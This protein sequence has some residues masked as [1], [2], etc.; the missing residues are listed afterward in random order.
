MKI[1]SEKRDEKRK[2]KK[3]QVLDSF[4]RKYTDR[5]RT[6]YSP[7]FILQSVH[8]LHTQYFFLLLFVLVYTHSLVARTIENRLFVMWIGD[9][10]F[11]LLNAD[12]DH[13]LYRVSIHFYTQHSMFIHIKRHIYASIVHNRVCWNNKYTDVIN[14][15]VFFY[16]AARCVYFSLFPFVCPS[17][18]IY[19]GD[20]CMC[21]MQ[22][23]KIDGQCKARDKRKQ[24]ANL[25]ESN[26]NKNAHRI[27]Q[28][29]AVR[30]LADIS[31]RM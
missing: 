5:P 6:I 17:A 9:A 4:I 3:I 21:K 12:W 15:I 24:K 16:A 25:N 23:Y 22:T 27:Q 26:E 14:F 2:Q 29:A 13:V 18:Q 28:I 30:S 1:R 20:I 31:V 11:S 19:T 7:A 8:M 10:L